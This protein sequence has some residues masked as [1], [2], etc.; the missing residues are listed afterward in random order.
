VC[1]QHPGV[2]RRTV[3]GETGSTRAS[4]RVCLLPPFFADVQHGVF[5]RVDKV[6]SDSD[7]IL[8]ELFLCSCRSP[9]KPFAKNSYTRGQRGRDVRIAPTPQH[10]RRPM[11]SVDGGSFTTARLLTGPRGVGWVDLLF[12]RAGKIPPKN[13]RVR[14]GAVAGVLIAHS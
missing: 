2:T 10:R 6:N 1:K 4:S 5:C 14:S 11:S 3:S 13:F 8:S 7:A 12:Y 9:I